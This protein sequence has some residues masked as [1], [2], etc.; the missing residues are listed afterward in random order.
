[1][2]GSRGV[3]RAL[4]DNGQPASVGRPELKNKTSSCLSLQ[5]NNLPC[6]F[7]SSCCCTSSVN[8]KWSFLAGGLTYACYGLCHCLLWFTAVW[9]NVISFLCVLLSGNAQE[10]AS[11]VETK[12]SSEQCFKFLFCLED[13][14]Q[15]AAEEVCGFRWKRSATAS[16]H[17]HAKFMQLAVIR[18]QVER[19]VGEAV[20]GGGKILLSCKLYTFMVFEL[21]CLC[22]VKCLVCKICH[23]FH[24]YLGTFH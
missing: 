18:V 16:A 10:K 7:F 12:V 6:T 23:R 2:E 24:E 8:K 13:L 4:A 1:M 20:R 17:T 22:F 9:R 19:G 3:E 11:D 14:S 21:F 5:P 15:V